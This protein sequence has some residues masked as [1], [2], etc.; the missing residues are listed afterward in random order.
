MARAIARRAA[1]QDQQLPTVVNFQ[2]LPGW[3]AHGCVEGHVMFVGRNGLD[4]NLPDILRAT[5]SAWEASART[6]VFVS[7]DGHTIGAIALGDGIRPTAAAAVSE[8][9]RLGL[10]S[11]LLTGDHTGAAENIASLVGIEEIIAGVSPP[12]KSATVKS[13]QDRGRRVAMVGDGIND[14]P[15]L[16]AADLGIAIGTGTD[17]ARDTA[18]VIITHDDLTA[19]PTAVRL[20]CAAHQTIR[21]NLAWA[22]GYNVVAIPLAA[23]GLLNPLIAGAA[24]ALSSACVVWNSARLRHFSASPVPAQPSLSTPQQQVAIP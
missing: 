18:E 16:A 8:L 12:E 2:V 3:G 1:E 11:V 10:H 15:A 20:A 21:Q 7:R 13:L 23:C 19:V 9:E 6:V 22:F 4:A 14:G 17:V 24:M 5:C